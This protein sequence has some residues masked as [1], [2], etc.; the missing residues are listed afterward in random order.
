MAASYKS[1]FCRWL[2]GVGSQVGKFNES[3][4]C[5][6]NHLGHLNKDFLLLLLLPV[7][8]VGCVQLPKY[9]QPQFHAPVDKGLAN[10]AGFS[11]R[12]LDI[13]DFQAESL[14]PD[15]DQYNHHIGA[16]SCISIRPSKDLKIR[17]VQSYYQNMLFYVGTILHLKFEAVFVPECSWWN[18]KLA[19]GREGYVL[20]HE[21]I[22]FAL[23]EIFARKLTLEA[24]NEVKGYLAIGR[25]VAESQEEIK[26]KLQTMA[27]E[28][29]KVS[30]EGH[31]DFDEDTS[32]FYDP[33][34]QR[35]W[36]ERVDVRLAE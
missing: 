16:Q 18:P 24:N 29:M 6:M 34:A 21:Q 7:L 33:R 36:L 20:Q 11:Y 14:S 25:T 1:K 10:R 9:A 27:R 19:K 3:R 30:V 35:R 4:R 15:Y 12:Q 26:K 8:I 5:Q 23:T 31:T 2:A 17:I 28:A 32:M 13:K 22:H